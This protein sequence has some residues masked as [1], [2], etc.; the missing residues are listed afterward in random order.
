MHEGAFIAGI[1]TQATTRTN[2]EVS[3]LAWLGRRRG[4]D[5]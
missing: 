1:C 2:I 4:N 3:R 5:P